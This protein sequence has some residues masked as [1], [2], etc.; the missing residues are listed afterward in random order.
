MKKV[1]SNNIMIIGRT[2]SGKSTI[3]SLLL[4][5]TEVPG[6][7]TLKSG[8]RDALI[9]SFHIADIDATLNIIDTPGLFERGS[10]T[11]SIRNN[12]A[13][14]KTIEKCANLEITSF[15]M[16]C[17][18]AVITAGINGE[19]V[20]SIELFIKFLGDEISNNSCLIITHC[21]AKNGEQRKMIK[22][23]LEED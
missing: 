1:K 12:E 4:D 10:D 16:I 9:E 8:T 15:N 18:C 13:I 7:L 5:P 2:R 17:F 6:E 22:K 23:E 3:K 11:N 14:L 21:E 20:Q 19:D